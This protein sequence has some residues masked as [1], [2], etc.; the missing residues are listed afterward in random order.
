MN[1]IFPICFY[2]QSGRYR[3]I[4]VIVYV[5]GHRAFSHGSYIF[6]NKIYGDGLNEKEKGINGMGTAL[7]RKKGG[8]NS[9]ERLIYERQK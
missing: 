2:I 4:R 1:R 9:R 3:S 5:Y 7:M 8:V 6:K